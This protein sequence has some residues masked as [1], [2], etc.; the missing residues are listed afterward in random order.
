MA[1]MKPH[2]KA[3]YAA[4]ALFYRCGRYVAMRYAEK[5]GIVGLYRLARQLEAMKEGPEEDDGRAPWSREPA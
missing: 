3:I 5:N 2:Q 4:S 1:T